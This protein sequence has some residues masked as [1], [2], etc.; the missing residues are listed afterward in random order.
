[1]NMQELLDKPFDQYQRYRDVQ[2]SVDIIKKMDGQEKLKILDVGGH[3]YNFEGEHELPLVKFLPLDDVTVLDVKDCPLPNYVKGDGM[4]LPFNDNEFDLITSMDVLEHIPQEGRVKFIKEMA[5]VSKGYVILSAPF[6][7]VNTELAE[8]ALFEYVFLQLKT[9]HEQLKEHISN[10]LPKYE[11]IEKILSAKFSSYIDFPSGNIDNWLYM[12]IL[13][14]RL[15]AI[16]NST[17]YHRL[18]DR[19]YNIN[20]YEQDHR[21]P[22]YRKVI[23]S[24]KSN[25]G[26]SV[27]KEI[28]SK[29]NNLATLMDNKQIEYKFNLL[30][31]MVENL[32]QKTINKIE[33]NTDRIE[34]LSNLLRIK[35]EEIFTLNQQY[36][37]A[38]Y[39][40][41]TI[42][43]SKGWRAIEKFRRIKNKL[44]GKYKTNYLSKVKS[45]DIE[46]IKENIKLFSYKPKISIVMPVY[47][48]DEEWLTKAIDS[49]LGQAYENW[50]ICM[51]DDASPKKHV[52]PLLQ[53]YELKDERIK[54]KYID[55][56]EGISGASNQ[57]ASLATG[58]F[59]ALLDNDDELAPDALY[60]VVKLL[61]EHNEADLIYS[62]ED[63]INTKGNFCEPFFKPD[64]CPD[65]LLSMN[66]ICHLGVYRK[67][68]FDA[69][70]GF[71]KG[72]E[73]SQDY[74]LV[75]R[76]TEETKNIFHIPNILYHWRKIP[77]SAA[78]TENAKPYAFTAA[79]KALTEAMERRGEKASIHDSMNSGYYNVKREIIGRPLV[80][81]IIP[82][83]DKVGLLIKLLKSIEEKTTY[84]NY[85]IIL[86]NNCSIE[87]KTLRFLEKIKNKYM[88][89]D[90]NE[91]FNFSKIN[92]WASKQ[93]T[94]EILLF[95]NNDLEVINNEWMEAMLEH[96]QRPEVGAVGAKLYY[97]NDTIQHSGVIIGIGGVANHAHLN[98]P[99]NDR[100]YFGFAT[101]VRNYSAVTAA[102]MMMRKSVFEKLH[103]FDEVNL[104]V[105]FNDV[106]FCLRLREKGYL[107]VYTPYAELYHYESAT[108]GKDLDLA[109][110]GYMMWRW[111]DILTKGDPCYNPNLTLER[112]DFSMK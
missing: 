71:R 49:V 18:L 64:W 93:A 42:K 1:M 44:S 21:L 47:N 73:G 50:E 31:L 87:N 55:Q 101:V 35:D 95:L 111:K 100:G 74:D 99:R 76:F 70:G 3:H 108:R 33:V 62:D 9:R 110:V 98:F 88:V 13:K 68:I 30:K 4:S 25:S 45:V 60:E 80:S 89:L 85:E 15:L 29:F 97:S 41:Q 8:K 109:E 36:T 26:D 105:A 48:V 43:G 78:A 19:Y 107:V 83:K 51:C 94:G 84:D 57:A 34:E 7:S 77:G 38:N 91:S 27:L 6:Y 65:L 67:S 86:V 32:P 24:S 54:V 90:Y 75:L 20:L 69:I 112:G 79:K 81:I 82:F 96:A 92:N 37:L 46:Q 39:E 61:Q 10:G 66:Y 52:K 2:I 5:R 28:K 53:K 11:E 40:L 12:M 104:K 17:D 102:C 58:E 106:D 22:S 23:V 59:I 63:K 14:H 103:G 56:N 16:N 72:F